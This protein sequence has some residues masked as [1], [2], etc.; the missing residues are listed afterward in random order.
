[1]S[2]G[3]RF[4][5][6]RSREK[7]GLTKHT[8]LTD[9]MCASYKINGGMWLKLYDNATGFSTPYSFNHIQSSELSCQSNKQS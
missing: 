1:M 8:C 6:N 5:T 4:N 3:L 7:P 2:A 9:F